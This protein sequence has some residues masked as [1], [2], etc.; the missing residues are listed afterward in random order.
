MQRDRDETHKFICVLISSDTMPF[1]IIE[2]KGAKYQGTQFI[3]LY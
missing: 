2:T 3:L 1:T